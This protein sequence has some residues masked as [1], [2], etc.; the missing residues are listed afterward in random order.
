MIAFC[1]GTDISENMIEY[2]NETFNSDKKRLQFEVLD[3]ETKNLP[4]KYISEFDHVYSF[5]TLM[6]CNDIR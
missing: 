2:A 5:H 4:K 6:W 1:K 3:I